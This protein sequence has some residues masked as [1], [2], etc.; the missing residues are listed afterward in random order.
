MERASSLVT[1]MEMG[2]AK[3]MSTR[4]KVS[5]RCCV[6]GCGLT[7]E[8]R[9]KACRSLWVSLSSFIMSGPG[10]EALG[11]PDRPIVGTTLESIMSHSEKW[12]TWL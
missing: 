10:K 5:G 9:R 1:M 3:C 12:L 6:P 2:S 11:C 8:F 4:W 7:G